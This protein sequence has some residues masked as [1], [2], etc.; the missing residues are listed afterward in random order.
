MARKTV[1]R[2]IVVAIPATRTVA[3][4]RVSTDEQSANGQSLAVQEGNCAAGRR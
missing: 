2:Q 4:T 3:Y 1:A